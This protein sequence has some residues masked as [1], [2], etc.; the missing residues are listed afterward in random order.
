VPIHER[1]YVG[2]AT[3]EASQVAAPHLAPDREVG[4]VAAV[5]GPGQRDLRGGVRRCRERTGRRRRPRLRRGTGSIGP[6]RRAT[7]VIRPDLIGISGARRQV[8]VD[9]ARHIRGGA[10]VA[11]KVAA[12]Y[13]APDRE[14][15]L[16][17]TVVRPCERSLRGGVSRRRQ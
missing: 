17:P 10:A 3:A 12:A 14:A 6:V 5:V 1:L 2:G 4:F 7:R 9:E 15:S 13:L 8:A 16:I 11:G